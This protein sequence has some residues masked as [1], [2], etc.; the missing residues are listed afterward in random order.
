RA[1]GEEVLYTLP[2]WD[3]WISTFFPYN[4]DGFE[5]PSSINPFEIPSG[6]VNVPMSLSILDNTFKLNVAAGFMGARQDK[7][8]D[9]YIVSPV[10]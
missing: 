4:K 5:M 7:V 9:E 6:L 8:D 1:S 10:I 3:G 2:C